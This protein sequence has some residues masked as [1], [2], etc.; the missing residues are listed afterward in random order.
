MDTHEPRHRDPILFDTLVLLAIQS[1]F[2]VLSRRF[3]LHALPTLRNISKQGSLS[4]GPAEQ[5]DEYA[6]KSLRGSRGGGNEDDDEFD[7]EAND[8]LLNASGGYS[9]IEAGSQRNVTSKSRWRRELE[10]DS[11]DETSDETRPYNGSPLPSPGLELANETDSRRP[12]GTSSISLIKQEAGLAGL[13]QQESN[14]AR[15]HTRLSSIVNGIHTPTIRT[16]GMP[17][18]SSPTATQGR[19][20]EPQVIRLFKSKGSII[21]GKTEASQKEKEKAGATRGLGFLAR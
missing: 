2:Y 13:D 7:D 15:G 11:E 20:Q 19:K 18:S 4:E 5:E 1:G 14:R 10:S 8:R 6:M 17:N 16:P 3:L 9:D 21:G 12:D